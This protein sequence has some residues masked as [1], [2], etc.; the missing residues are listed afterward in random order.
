MPAKT[1]IFYFSG[2]GN[3]LKI[4]RDLAAELG[5]AD[6]VSIAKAVKGGIDTSS[7]RI[8]LVFPVYAL[9]MP[10]IVTDFVKKADL[11]SARYIFA[12]I[13][14]ADVS[15]DVLGQ[16]AGR[17]KKKGL[18]LS[19]GFGIQMPNNYTPFYGA[20]PVEKQ[21]KFFAVAEGKVR[22]IAAIVKEERAHRIERS[23]FP[24]NLL[25][26]L[27]YPVV[28]PVT[29]NEDRKFW[30]DERCNGCGTCEKVCP[31][32]NLYMK[33]KKPVWLH[34]CV[35]CL[36]CLQW[37]PTESIQWGKHTKSRKRYRNPFVSVKDFF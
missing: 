22:E 16:L 29:P 8:G 19:A 6:I 14:Y 11:K 34:K 32:N 4:A 23:R 5:D 13:T 20:I 33:D 3:C 35:Q 1:T 15:G 7:D 28:V 30:T 25:T 24:L 10:L 12:V 26:W 9:N 18:C 31:V 2:T 21:N 27:L 37:C 36:A 17:L